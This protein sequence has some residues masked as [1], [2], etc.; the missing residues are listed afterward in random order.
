MKQITNEANLTSE[1]DRIKMDQRSNFEEFCLQFALSI[2]SYF[3]NNFIYIEEYDFI[4]GTQEPN[5]YV[6]T[7]LPDLL[8]SLTYICQINMIPNDEI[9]KNCIEFWNWLCF[10]V[11]FIREK[12]ANPD[13]GIPISVYKNTL[14]QYV[15]FA[16][17]TFWYKNLYEK[18]LDNVRQILITKMTKPIEIKMEL[19]E[20]GELS[21][22]VI[23][24]T[25]N[26]SLNESMR[27]SLIYLTHLD[28]IIT[29]KFLI[30]T[31]KS[32][33]NDSN[34]N[35]HLL[36]SLCWAI[37]SI[38]GAMEETN[39]KGFVVLVIKYLLN[40]CEHKKGK[41]NKAVVASNIMYVVGQ[42]PRFLNSH[43]KFLKT[44]IKKLFEF[45]HET[46]P[47]VQDFACETFMKIAIKC[48]EETAKVNEGE[49]EPYINTLVRTIKDDTNDLQVHQK[50]MFYESIGIMISKE[51]DY[52][53]QAYYVQQM[54]QHSYN[55]WFTIFQ[56]ASSN[57]DILQNNLAIKSLD[58]TLKLNE[59]VAVSVGTAYYSFATHILENVLKAY[60]YYSSGVNNAYNTKTENL[61]VI[62]LF[63]VIKKTILKY[64]QSL[65]KS[66]DDKDIIL[67]Q[68]LP[69]LAVLIEQY[70]YSHIENRDA[71]VLLVF[72]EVLNKIK[73]SQYE[74]IKNIWQYLCIFTLDMIKMDFQSYPE[75]RTN[76]FKLVKSLIFN[77]FDGK[78]TC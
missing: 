77:A 43:W 46:H 74:Y 2:M 39:E 33:M 63:K 12:E 50:L 44:V 70:R 64:L 65:V 51:P 32:Q 23:S 54:M 52:K 71:D 17:D 61:P 19:D 15:A 57:P 38:T 42:Y 47:G 55:D 76:F 49:S 66:I 60:A 4:N 29:E 37:G 31:L 8:T 16:H 11:C 7:Y 21:T 45:M 26:Q 58:I 48:G 68:I 69:Q 36:N 59:R 30:D 25:I 62:K 18:I 5:N 75:H 10:K 78:F 6:I 28:P 41:T 35:P 34:W 27:D 56:N 20:S 22:E 72:S 24:G 3:K 1:Y 73:N 14:S 13:D 67:N 9:F 40:L 53:K